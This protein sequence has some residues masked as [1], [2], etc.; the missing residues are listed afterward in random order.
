MNQNFD[1]TP[2][3]DRSF[4][5]QQPLYTPPKKSNKFATAALVLGICSVAASCLCCCLYYLSAPLS[6]LAFIMAALSKKRNDGKMSGSAVAGIILAVLGIAI[7]ICCLAFEVWFYFSFPEEE[8]R[9][10]FYDYF[11]SQGTS[12][13]EYVKQLTEATT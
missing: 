2:Q 8:I 9:D 6:I 1:Y 4:F 10:I 12:F 7:F 13:S 5:E 11:E 3:N